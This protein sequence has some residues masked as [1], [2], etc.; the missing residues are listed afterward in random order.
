MNRSKIVVDYVFAYNVATNIMQ[1]NED[2][3]PQSIIECQQRND[4]PKWQEAI[5]SEL[6]SLAKREDFGPIV[7]TPNGIKSVNYKW[8]FVR[9]RNEKNEIQRYKARLVAQGF[10]QRLDIDY[11]ETYSPVMDAITLR[12]LIS[13]TV[14]EQLEMHLMDMV[15]TYLYGSLDNEIKDL[16][17][18]NHVIQ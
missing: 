18:L 5:Q 9:K 12:S 15:T 13:F 11:E 14:H 3:E 16:R 7:Q 4:W 10:S 1:D 8:I 2:H 17:C 6:N